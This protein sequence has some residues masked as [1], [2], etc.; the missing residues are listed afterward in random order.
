M[1]LFIHVVNKHA[2]TATNMYYKNL[3]HEST[4]LVPMPLPV[5]QCYMQAMSGQG[6]R[7]WIHLTNQDQILMLDPL[8]AL[9]SALS[10]HLALI[11][12]MGRPGFVAAPPLYYV[13]IW[14]NVINSTFAECMICPQSLGVG[15]RGMQV[16][17]YGVVYIFQHSGSE[18][19]SSIKWFHWH[20]FY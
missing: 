20:F 12:P 7:H 8:I 10:H 9:K 14:R 19:H 4:S 5:F 1:S 3:I 16:L 11:T 2:T 18:V 6:M 15:G 17:D 13:T